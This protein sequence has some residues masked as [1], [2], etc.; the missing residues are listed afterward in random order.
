MWTNRLKITVSQM[1]LSLFQ[2]SIFAF[3]AITSCP[4]RFNS[5]V[6]QIYFSRVPNSNVWPYTHRTAF[7]RF[8]SVCVNYTLTCTPLWLQKLKPVLAAYC[9]RERERQNQTLPPPQSLRT[10]WH[11]KSA[12]NFTSANCLVLSVWKERKLVNSSN[13]TV[14]I[15][16]RIYFPDYVE[17]THCEKCQSHK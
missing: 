7:T 2:S 17:A 8:R 10:R 13:G 3:V 16:A 15:A 6:L 11:W 5:F 14:G 12:T 9:S 1:T 4:I